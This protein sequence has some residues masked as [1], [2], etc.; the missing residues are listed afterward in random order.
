MV[1]ARKVAL[2]D[3][4]KLVSRFEVL[5]VGIVS[6][7]EGREL[8][9]RLRVRVGGAATGTCRAVAEFR[10]VLD[11]GAIGICARSGADSHCSAV[12]A[13]GEVSVI[14]RLSSWSSQ[15]QTW[16]LSTPRDST[17]GMG[18]RLFLRNQPTSPST[19]LCQ[20]RNRQSLNAG[21]SGDLVT[22]PCAPSGL[23]GARFHQMKTSLWMVLVQA[24]T[25]VLDQT[26]IFKSR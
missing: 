17:T 10:K 26:A 21:A 3:R 12:L 22:A 24:V 2:R 8:A 11:H 16:S 14:R 20:P 1:E 9:P 25:R 7:R 5:V 6:D 18:E 13:E 19:P 23:P 4:D 15:A